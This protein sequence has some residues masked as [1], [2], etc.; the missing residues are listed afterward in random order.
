MIKLL[1]FINYK[2]DY[3]TLSPPSPIILSVV[4]SNSSMLI[5]A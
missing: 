3:V 5:N 2:L 4:P 1:K